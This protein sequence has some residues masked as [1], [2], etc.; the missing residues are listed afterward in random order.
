[1]GR[2]EHGGDVWAH[3]D[4]LDFSANLSPLGMPH[5]VSEA[6][7]DAVESGAFEAYPDPHCRELVAGIAAALEIPA[8]WVLPT[9]GA[10]DLMSR[11]CLALRPRRALVAAPCYSGYE[12]ALEQAGAQA[13]R[14]ELREEEGFALTDRF[15][16]DVTGGGSGKAPDLVILASPN[17]PTG[18]TI[19]PALVERIVE[20]AEAVGARVLLDECFLDFT[21]APSAVRL[22]AEHP[23]LIVMR[24]FT[25][26]YAMAGLR[27]GYGVCSDAGLLG[28]LQA[29]GQ[30]WAVS[31]PAQVAG[32][33]ALRARADGY[34][35][36]SRAHVAEERVWLAGQ[37]QAP[38]LAFRVI[39][40]EANYLLFDAGHAVAGLYERLLQR[41]ILIRRCENYEGLRSA[42]HRVAVRA[43]AE[44]ER[45]VE[46]LK[47]CM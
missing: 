19:A 2:F 30:P 33:A 31:T 29:A 38:P 41:G 18:L 40:G 17:N 15:L 42:W 39:P 32:L 37:L 16:D 43:H 35:E 12:Q 25:K 27:L 6:L 28:R 4:A 13:A 44:N 8:S 14:H 36:R 21:E 46:A 9:A 24:A 34:V 7:R 45:L 22:C 23:N 20:A 47:G 10:T 5:E 11:V 3:P 26:T 1:M